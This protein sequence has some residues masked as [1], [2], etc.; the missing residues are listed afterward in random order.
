MADAGLAEILLAAAGQD[1]LACEALSTVAGV[2]DAIV[3]FH[4]Q[5]C[6]EK[7]IKAVLVCAGVAFRRTHDL[8][9]LLDL[10][11]DHGVVPPPGADWLDELNP[12]GVA[13]RYG[14]VVPGRL[15]RPR[16]LAAIRAVLAWAAAHPSNANGSNAS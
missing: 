11:A 14:L 6:V 1:L 13:A 7:S 12:Y 16:V 3:G 8:A 2:G 5:Q 9:E 10:A 4:A 15:D